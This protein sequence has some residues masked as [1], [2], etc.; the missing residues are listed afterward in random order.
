LKISPGNAAVIVGPPTVGSNVSGDRSII[1]ASARAHVLMLEEV[2][3]AMYRIDRSLFH[4]TSNGAASTSVPDGCASQSASRRRLSIDDARRQA[5]AT[6][7]HRAA[8]HAINLH[9]AQT[10]LCSVVN[11]MRWYK[12]GSRKHRT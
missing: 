1:Q 6:S 11:R 2:G 10:P 8:D 5:L 9:V 3:E 12:I 7:Q 4:I